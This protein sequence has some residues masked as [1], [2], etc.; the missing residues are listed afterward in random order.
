MIRL[1]GTQ[2]DLLRPKAVLSVAVAR[3]RK[4][5]TANGTIG[6]GAITGSPEHLPPAGPTWTGDG[7]DPDRDGTPNGYL[8]SLVIGNIAQGADL[9]LGT[10]TPAEDRINALAIGDG[11]RLPSAP[12]SSLVATSFGAGSVTAPSIGSMIVRGPMAADVTVTVEVDPAKKALGLLR[13]KGA[14]MGSDIMVAGNV[15]TC[16]QGVPDRPAVRRIHRRGRRHRTFNLPATVTT[17]GHRQVRR[18]PG[19]PSHCHRL[20]V[21][22]DHQFYNSPDVT[23]LF[24][25]TRRE[26][27][28][29]TV[30]GPAKWKYDAALPT[31]GP[32]RLPK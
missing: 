15:G 5:L 24:G 10:P 11:R 2:P 16:G 32:R 18:L 28:A 21:G 29:V 19:Q 22:G 8:G 14:V 6:L 7:I 4:S 30:T 27:G 26:L 20:Q 13:V 25:F 31:P 17:S 3:P 9:H 23:T 12:V 1:D